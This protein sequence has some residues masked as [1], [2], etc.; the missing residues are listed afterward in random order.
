MSRYSLRD[1]TKI[2]IVVRADSGG[3]YGENPN[4]FEVLGFPPG[5]RVY[6]GHEIAN[7]ADFVK[8]LHVRAGNNGDQL[9][10]GYWVPSWRQVETACH[11][12]L[13]D[14]DLQSVR[15]PSGPLIPRWNPWAS[16]GSPLA[17]IPL[18]HAT[19]GSKFSNDGRTSR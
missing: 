7:Q 10:V 19:R 9:T 1:W 3:G 16:S 2:L 8:T 17:S 15:V 13:N 14:S 11:Q 12:L 4:P 6:S 18:G 5:E